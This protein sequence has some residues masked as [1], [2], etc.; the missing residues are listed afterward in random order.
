M[1]YSLPP[2]RDPDARLVDHVLVRSQ[3]FLHD[4]QPQV[5]EIFAYWRERCGGRRMPRRCDVDP[6]DLGRLLPNI[7][8]IDVVNDERRFVYRVV[9]TEEV[10]VR[11]NDPT[12]KAVAEAFYGENR[13]RVLAKY[14]Q[15]CATRS[16]L[17][18][19]MSYAAPDKP[20]CHDELLHLPL[21]EDGESV[22]QILV[23]AGPRPFTEARTA[24]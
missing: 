2:P 7:L 23:Y 21:S 16:F 3:D 4:C 11:G 24:E 8:L 6:A 1:L 10:R 20:L 17:F 13:E 5:A 19:V 14:E 22:S 9:G 12:G 18:S 15:V